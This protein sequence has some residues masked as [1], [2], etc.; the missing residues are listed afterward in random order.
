[1][2]A[3]DAYL[4]SFLN[5]INAFLRVRAVAHD[6]PQAPHLVY[7]TLPPDIIQHRLQGSQVG[8]DICK[9]SNTHLGII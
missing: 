9:Y 7:P 2:V 8:M 3:G 4:A 6:V 1:M 5:N